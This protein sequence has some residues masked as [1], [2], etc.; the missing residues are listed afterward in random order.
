MMTPFRISGGNHETDRL[1]G[2]PGMVATTNEAGSEGTA[3]KKKGA[4]SPFQTLT[5]F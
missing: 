5:W 3:G 2:E 4:L 1:L